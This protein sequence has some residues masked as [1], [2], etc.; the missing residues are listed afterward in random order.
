MVILTDSKKDCPSVTGSPADAEGE[1]GIRVCSGEERSDPFPFENL[2][3]GLEADCLYVFP[4]PR[5]VIPEEV[6]PGIR[7]GV[8]SKAETGVAPVAPVQKLDAICPFAT[9]QVQAFVFLF[10]TQRLQECVQSVFAVAK[11]RVAVHYVDVLRET[12]QRLS[13]DCS[14]P[15]A[16]SLGR[17]FRHDCHSLYSM[18]IAALIISDQKAFDQCRIS[19]T[20]SFEE[21]GTCQAR[22]GGVKASGRDRG[23]GHLSWTS[24]HRRSGEATTCRIWGCDVSAAPCPGT[25]SEMEIYWKTTASLC[26]YNQRVKRVKAGI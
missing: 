17:K 11:I 7:S 6:L 4:L 24:L 5:P 26:V 18:G 14:L 19:A 12:S 23:P 13:H 16:G 2:A 10:A 21:D 3:E 25:I 1:I 20:D 22:Y 15:G 9:E 8:L